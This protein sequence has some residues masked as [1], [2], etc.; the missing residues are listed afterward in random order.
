LEEIC[1]KECKVYSRIVGYY[2]PISQW[3]AGK[4]EEFRERKTFKIKEEELEIK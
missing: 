3:N 4:T 1:G 2:R